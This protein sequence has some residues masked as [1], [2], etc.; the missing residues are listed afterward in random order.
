MDLSS[1][2]S[3][4]P[5]TC[6]E[7]PD[8]GQTAGI[9]NYTWNDRNLYRTNITYLCPFG[10]AFDEE[11]SREINNTCDFQSEN[12]TKVT[13]KYNSDRPLPSCIGESD[14]EVTWRLAEHGKY[15]SAY[16]TAGLPR[17]PDRSD[18]TVTQT[19]DSVGQVVTFTCQPGFVFVG[20]PVD[21]QSTAPTTTTI[22]T[23]TT[24]TTT[25]TPAPLD[26]QSHAGA[27]WALVVETVAV[28]WDQAQASC[29]AHQADL[30]SVTSWEIQVVSNI[31]GHLT[32]HLARNG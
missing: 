31:S 23:T 14:K 7:D 27:E 28:T 6:D 11:Y 22:T 4:V 1:V 29:Q 12:D 30:A 13:W 15:F 21:T 20:N 26:W 17:Q 2:T 8:L 16:C 25:T 32:R 18:K 3:C 24:T 9:H 5:M 19:L 10:Q